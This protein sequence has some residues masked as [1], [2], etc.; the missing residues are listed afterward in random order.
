MLTALYSTTAGTQGGTG[1]R[2][3]AADFFLA[4]GKAGDPHVP[5]AFFGP[6]A[7]I[8]GKTGQG[9]S[10]ADFFRAPRA[11][12]HGGHERYDPQDMGPA[13]AAAWMGPP[14]AAM[15]TPYE[16]EAAIAQ[17]DQ[18]PFNGELEMDSNAKDSPA[19]L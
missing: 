2:G 17:G 1:Q 4:P 18:E 15:G 3:S 6:T 9:R 13:G 16:K 5:P 8:Q 10:A 14:A 11:F 12:T 19:M 7:E